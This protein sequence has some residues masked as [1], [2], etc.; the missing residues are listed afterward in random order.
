MPEIRIGP[1]F[2]ATR[3][4]LSKL[5]NRMKFSLVAGFRQCGLKPLRVA[6]FAKID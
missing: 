4:T 6:D 1:M 3:A 5:V 2:L